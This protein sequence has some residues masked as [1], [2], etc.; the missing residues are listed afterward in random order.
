MARYRL[1]DVLW[2]D[3]ATSQIGRLEDPQG[4]IKL[5]T[6][7]ARCLKLLID[8]QGE[9][10]DKKTL[11]HEC[12]GKF[13]TLVTDSSMWKDISLLRQTFLALGIPF[14]VII[15]VPRIGYIFT[16]E[17]K[18]EP[19]PSVSAEPEISEPVTELET[20]SVEETAITPTP[21]VEDRSVVAPQQADESKPHAP[22]RRPFPRVYA[23]M[24]A[25]ILLNAFSAVGYYFYNLHTSPL[26]IFDSTQQYRFFKSVG[27]TQIFLQYPI[28]DDSVYAREAL[29][30]FEQQKPKTITGHTVR[31]LYINRVISHEFS[32]YFL[33]NSPMTEKN[34]RCSAY[35]SMT[36]QAN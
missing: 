34:N 19:L 13:G 1:H 31:Y 11:M 20:A 18:V 26:Q 24:L 7:S 14:D 15:T 17:L 21:P 9:Q 6:T 33:C 30:R 5:S 32:S 16:S 8:N 36:N 28:E 23:I 4:A 10:V 35:F 25:C 27:E 22:L 2:F 29:A 12:W 3:D